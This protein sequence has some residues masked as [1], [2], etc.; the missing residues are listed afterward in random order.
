MNRRQL[1]GGSILAAA[2]TPRLL[3]NAQS[4]TP[5][6]DKEAQYVP[7]FAKL[8][9]VEQA[10]T[11]YAYVPD[12]G[13]ATA[14]GGGLYFVDAWGLRFRTKSQADRAP[15]EMVDAY[16]QWIS[17]EWEVRFR[18]LD[19]AS[20]R[21]LG[22]DSR[23]WVAELRDPEEDETYQWALL[24]VRKDVTVQ[25]LVGAS[26]AGTPLRRLA[27]VSEQTLDRWPNTDRRRTYDG[28]PAGGIWD[29]LPRLDDLEEGMVIDYSSD[30]TDEF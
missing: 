13:F 9:G 14:L 17:T 1:L 23:G 5:I 19:E 16:E 26:Y 7:D 18:N 24:S 8:R 25:L 21:E 27:D 11:R 2:F 29:T 15:R 22:D 4:S 10:V 30:I 20:A 12:I 3:A 28:E 6:P